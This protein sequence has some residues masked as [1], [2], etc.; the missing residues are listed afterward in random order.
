MNLPSS[1]CPR[2]NGPLGAAELGGVGVLSCPKCHG[3]L[4][5]QP[6]L[7]QVLE[8]LSVE[9]LKTFD[10]DTTGRPLVDHGPRVTCPRCG[11][12]MAHDDYCDA[13]LVFFDRCEPCGLIWVDPDELGTMTLMWARMERR[14]QRDHEQSERLLAEVGAFVDRVLIARAI[15][16]L[17]K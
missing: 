16:N 12:T 5:A 1:A 13:N 11:R 4:L 8:G 2:C 3:T 17:M 14:Q 7:A 9:L 10:P 6:L 15:A